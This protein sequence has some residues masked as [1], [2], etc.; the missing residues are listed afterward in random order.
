MKT[1]FVLFNKV[2]L[3]SVGEPL[4]WL[5]P[6][7][8][9]FSSVLSCVVWIA[10]KGNNSRVQRSPSSLVRLVLSTL[11]LLKPLSPGWMLIEP[12]LTSKCDHFH[13]GSHLGNSADVA[14]ACIRHPGNRRTSTQPEYTSLEA[15]PCVCFVQVHYWSAHGHGQS[16]QHPCRQRVS[17]HPQGAGQRRERLAQHLRHRHRVQ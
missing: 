17:V 8:S 9:Y 13:S 10:K 1:N 6:K 4:P 11:C 14:A 7:K 2:G 15:D 3:S 12:S 16:V 5:K